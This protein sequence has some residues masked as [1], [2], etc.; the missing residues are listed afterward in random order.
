L[1]IARDGVFVS[2]EDGTLTFHRLP[3]LQQRCRRTSAT[4][5]THVLAF[6]ERRSVIESRHEPTLLDD[7]SAE[8]EPVF[9]ALASAAVGGAAPAGPER[10]A[11]SRIALRDASGMRIDSALSVAEGGFSLHAATTAAADD[12]AGREALCKYVLRPPLAQ[13]R[14]PSAGRWPRAH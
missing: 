5:R 14:L 10:R 8:Q 3:S 7:G 4:I 13:E 9:A 12:D 1:P 11:R 2:N 6:L